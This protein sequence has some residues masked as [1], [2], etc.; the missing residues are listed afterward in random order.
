MAAYRLD[1]L[2][3]SSFA[4]FYPNTTIHL[5]FGSIALIH[6]KHYFCAA[7]PHFCNA[8]SLLSF[9]SCGLSVN[10]PTFAV[11]SYHASPCCWRVCGLLRFARFA[12]RARAAGEHLTTLAVLH[13]CHPNAGSAYVTCMA[14]L[15]N[16]SSSKK[17]WRAEKRQAA[18]AWHQ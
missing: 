9:G 3:K 16:T 11:Y 6:S 4:L 15:P 10:L 5:W 18:Q 14:S 1:V 17:R 13:C 2:S 7:F 8:R 12:W